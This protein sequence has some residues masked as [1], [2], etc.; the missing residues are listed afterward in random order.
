[1]C[2]LLALQ[3]QVHDTL[4]SWQFKLYDLDR[5]ILVSRCH[6]ATM[7]GV[8]VLCFKRTLSLWCLSLEK[9]SFEHN[10]GCKFWIKVNAG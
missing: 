7:S 3:V 8:G 5:T 10:L 9:E 6:K 2:A 4:L 1:M